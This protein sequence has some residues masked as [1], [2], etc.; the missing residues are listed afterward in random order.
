MLSP[1]SQAEL[2]QEAIPAP[3]SAA[4]VRLL[5]VNDRIRLGWRSSCVSR[6]DRGQVG[7][8]GERLRQ[9]PLA[10]QVTEKG[11]V[12]ATDQLTYRHIKGKGH[13]RHMG[14]PE[15]GAGLGSLQ[16]AHDDEADA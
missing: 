15:R 6:R 8:T 13:G 14:R 12:V 10:L 7:T 3:L 11:G 1:S 16:M 5:Q 4:A 2:L 9:W